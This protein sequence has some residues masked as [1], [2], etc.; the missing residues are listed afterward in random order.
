[1]A[2]LVGGVGVLD[3]GSITSITQYGGGSQLVIVNVRPSCVC[4]VACRHEELSS[5][6]HVGK[7]YTRARV[8]T[9]QNG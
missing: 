1:M 6:G 9:N 5:G 4:P 8:W 3:T 2:Q 7:A